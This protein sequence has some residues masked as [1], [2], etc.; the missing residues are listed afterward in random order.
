VSRPPVPIVLWG[1][2][3]AVLT[4]VGAAV[5]GFTDPAPLT[6]LGGAAA[7]TILFAAVVAWRGLGRT[8]TVEVRALPSISPPIPWL[9]V[10]ICWAMLGA[11]LG[12]WLVLIG[13]GVAT[14]GLAGLLREAGAQREAL[15]RARGEQAP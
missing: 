10:G 14:V 5:F 3:L 8:D 15:R 7:A 11:E 13:A 2:Y 6:L 1:V 9:A 12:L 4:G